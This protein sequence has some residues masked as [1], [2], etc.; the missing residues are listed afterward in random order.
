LGVEKT[1]SP[2]YFFDG[3]FVF[4]LFDE[5]LHFK[6]NAEFQRKNFSYWYLTA[7]QS[8]ELCRIKQMQ[9]MDLFKVGGI[10]QCFFPKLFFA[11]FQ[12][13]KPP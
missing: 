11:K 6:E 5:M 10:F 8:V 4:K 1:S 3:K 9:M 7:V 12:F 13:L 2:E